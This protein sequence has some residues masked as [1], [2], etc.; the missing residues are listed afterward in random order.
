VILESES[1]FKFGFWNGQGP[2]PAT[3]KEK[4]KA[5]VAKVHANGRKVRLWAT[6]D[7]LLGFQALLDIGVDYIGTDKLSL[8][9][10]YLK[11]GNSK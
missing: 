1:M 7:S 2:I 9:A 8:L 10:D 5:Y 11:L 6:P 3:L 4:L